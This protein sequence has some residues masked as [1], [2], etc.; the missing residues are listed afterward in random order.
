M[1]GCTSGGYDQLDTS[2]EAIE[3]ELRP[4]VCENRQIKANYSIDLLT[5]N[6][7]VIPLSMSVVLSTRVT[8]EA[9]VK[10]V[11]STMIFVLTAASDCRST[12]SGLDYVGNVNTT[13]SGRTCMAWS[14]QYVNT[15]FAIL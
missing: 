7:C 14:A 15:T 2:P 8:V 12:E 11:R 13:A 6:D 3:Q 10:D 1:I 4:A 5:N 9:C